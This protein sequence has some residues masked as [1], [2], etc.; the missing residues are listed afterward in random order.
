MRIISTY[1]VASVNDTP[2]N[3]TV[4]FGYMLKRGQGEL[5]TLLQKES[6]NYFKKIGKAIMSHTPDTPTEWEKI[7]LKYPGLSKEQIEKKESDI[8]DF[9]LNVALSKAEKL[10]L[11]LV[12][13][14]FIKFFINK[15]FPKNSEQFTSFKTVA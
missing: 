13:E 11:K 1:P 5:L 3:K 10:R 7:K 12:K 6:P 9:I 2:R 14:T 8:R 4:S 15:C